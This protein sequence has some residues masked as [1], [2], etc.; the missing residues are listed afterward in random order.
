MDAA[1]RDST[2]NGRAAAW[3]A[4]DEATLVGGMRSGVEHAFA[5]FFDRYKA[6]LVDTARRRGVAPEERRAYVTDFLGDAAMSLANPARAVPRSL[7]G[8]LTGG[9]R[10][11]LAQRRRNAKRREG[12][13]S[14][15]VGE[16]ESGAEGV[17]AELC[18][19]YTLQSAA[20]VGDRG[21]STA[22]DTST[23]ELRLRAAR[24]LLQSLTTDERAVLELLAERMPQREIA[25]ILGVSPGAVR[26]RI[27]RLRQRLVAAAIALTNTLPV[28][29]GRALA[30]LLMPRRAQTRGGKN[31]D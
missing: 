23:G 10:R 15:L 1:R 9:F 4:C 24:S 18:S 26:V 6:M 3:K 27:H 28:D 13:Q 14:G 31:G 25:A 12:R 22:K 16:V 19:A 29:E 8:Y 11:W 7:A 2:S 17:V 21:E 30:N 20:G 5:E